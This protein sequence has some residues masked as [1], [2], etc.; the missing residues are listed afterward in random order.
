MVAIFVDGDACPVK[1][2]VLKVAVRN[3]VQ[4]HL[5]ANSWHRNANHP[6]VHQVVVP[7]TPDAAD[8]WIAEHAGPGD[9]VVTADILLAAR[10]LENG[11]LVLGPDGRAFTKESIGM[12]VAM[13]DLMSE[14]R[15]Q[16]EV[17]SGGGGFGKQDRSRFLSAF[18]TAVKNALRS[19]PTE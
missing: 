18:E 6:L 15:D 10:G 16:G 11:A 7:E 1:D 9:L 19:H 3:Q 12:K 8:D 2:E 13:R 17:K 5:V 14:L 4:V